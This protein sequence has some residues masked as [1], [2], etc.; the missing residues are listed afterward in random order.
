MAPFCLPNSTK[1]RP[2]IDPEWYKNF[3][4]LGLEFFSI[5]GPLWIPAWGYVGRL[6][7]ILARIASFWGHTGTSWGPHRPIMSSGRLHMNSRRQH[8]I[9][10]RRRRS[11]RRRQTGCSVGHM[12]YEHGPAECAERCRPTLGG[13]LDFPSW[14]VINLSSNTFPD[15][16]FPTQSYISEVP[17]QKVVLYPSLILPVTLRIPPGRAK[18][19][20]RA[21][22]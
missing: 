17:G 7:T 4:R 14:S 13:V 19:I 11:F 16:S 22:P 21:L 15:I 8:M 20:V 18:S 3:G 6:E 5:F 9:S 2:K 1:N 10:A 12:S